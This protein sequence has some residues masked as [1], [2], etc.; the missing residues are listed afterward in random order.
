MMILAV[1]AATKSGFAL[2]RVGETPRAWSQRLKGGDDEPER[3]FKKMGIALRD[4]FAL[5]KPDLVVIEQHMLFAGNG[6][7]TAKTGYLLQGLV[8]SVFAICGPYSVKARLAAPQTVRRHFVGRARPD[9]PKREVLDR[10]KALGWVAP[11]FKDMDATDAAA[12]WSYGWKTYAPDVP[13]PIDS[14]GALI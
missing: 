12:V 2:G 7:S 8:A 3:A 1:D 14:L 9:D 5:E 13:H 10:C 6:Q 11:D 4:L